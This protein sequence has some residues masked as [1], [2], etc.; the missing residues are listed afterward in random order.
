MDNGGAGHLPWQIFWMWQWCVLVIGILRWRW[1]IVP[2][3]VLLPF[4]FLQPCRKERVNPYPP[5]AKHCFARKSQKQH[6]RPTH[7]PTTRHPHI[8]I[9][10]QHTLTPS[11]LPCALTM[12]PYHVPLQYTIV[13]YPCYVPSPCALTMCPYHLPLLCTLVPL[14]CT[15]AMYP[16]CVPLV[17]TL[18][19]YPCPHI[20]VPC[21]LVMLY[22]CHVP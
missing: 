15:I 19:V 10:I 9:L 16:W 6:S 13:M 8:L 21:T 4:L 18:A 5:R 22:P 20:H 12:Y 14:S 7:A 3:Y 17:C 2:I 11:P 1:A